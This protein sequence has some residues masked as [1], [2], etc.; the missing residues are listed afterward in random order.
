MILPIRQQR[1]TEDPV[2]PIGAGEL[3]MQGAECKWCTAV[4]KLVATKSKEIQK[5][6]R[7]E[8]VELEKRM[9]ADLQLSKMHADIANKEKELDALRHRAWQKARSL[10]ERQNDGG[11]E[12][13]EEV[14]S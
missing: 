11:S 8:I 13:W 5:Q 14:Q 7:A 12:E 3:R 10:M 2:V 1:K 9:S 4:L 6:A